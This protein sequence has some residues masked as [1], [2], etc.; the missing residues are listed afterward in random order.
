MSLTS[1]RQTVQALALSTVGAIG[2]RVTD[3]GKV[4]Q[5]AGP[6][7]ASA[8]RTSS[9][10]QRRVEK[11]WEFSGA[12]QAG[13]PAAADH[14]RLRRACASET[15][16]IRP[17]GLL[18]VST[19]G[20]GFREAVHAPEIGAAVGVFVDCVIRAVARCFDPEYLVPAIAAIDS[21]TGEGV[22]VR[23]RRRWYCLKSDSGL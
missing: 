7:S 13:R 17:R 23:G 12:R 5:P 8:T 20:A 21:D 19:R 9:L 2:S 11:R 16:A 6:G 3:S 22:G 1:L 10:N 4:P 15:R 18:R 14:G